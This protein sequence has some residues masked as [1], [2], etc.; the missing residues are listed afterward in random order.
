MS[1]CVMNR[2][3]LLFIDASFR[4]CSLITF[5][6]SLQNFSSHRFLHV[7]WVSVSKHVIFPLSSARYRWKTSS[8]FPKAFLCICE[9]LIRSQKLINCWYIYFCVYFGSYDWCCLDYS[10][11]DYDYNHYIPTVFDYNVETEHLTA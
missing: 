2:I 9:V 7:I 10:Q 4:M 8:F 1:C 5:S 3:F 6:Q 11:S